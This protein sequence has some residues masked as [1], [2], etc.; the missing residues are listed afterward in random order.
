M[1]HVG[2]G[3]KCRKH[4]SPFT[5]QIRVEDEAEETEEEADPDLSFHQAGKGFCSKRQESLLD[6]F[7]VPLLNK[8]PMLG[9]VWQLGLTLKVTL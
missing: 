9:Y 7:L 5:K 6:P 2:Q 4:L 3:K 8:E 1:C